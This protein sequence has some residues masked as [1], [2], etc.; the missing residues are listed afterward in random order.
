MA[1]DGRATVERCMGIYDEILS[2]SIEKLPS[3]RQDALRRLCESGELTAA[4][5]DE[6]YDLAKQ[7]QGLAPA[8]D[9]PIAPKPFSANHFPAEPGAADRVSLTSLRDL[10]NVGRIVPGQSLDLHPAGLTVIYGGNGSGKTGYARV[11]KQAC[12]ARS[13]GTVYPD[14]Y[15]EDFDTLVPSAE[16]QFTVNGVADVVSWKFKQPCRPEL[17]A[18]SVFESACDEQ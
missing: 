18:E 6:I 16:I 17:R 15:S 3:W 13:P 2:W 1:G 11:L 8:T 9:P 14:A 12:R 10:K 7:H 5:L 4:D